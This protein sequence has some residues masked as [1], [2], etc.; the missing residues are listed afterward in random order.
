MLLPGDVGI[1][2]EYQMLADELAADVLL[3]PHHGSRSSS[4]YAFIRAVKPRWVVFSAARHSQYGHPHPLV[5]ERYRELGA[6][7]VYTA[8]AGAIRFVLDD[9]GKTRQVWAWREHAR[10]FWHEDRVVGSPAQQR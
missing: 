5:V 9:A 7:P 1:R 8:S 4:S 10:R 2:G 6:E 3:A